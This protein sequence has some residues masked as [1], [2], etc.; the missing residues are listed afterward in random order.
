MCEIVENQSCRQFFFLTYIISQPQFSLPA[1]LPVSAPNLPSSPHHSSCFP[2][3]N[4]QVFRG[5]QQNITSYNKTRHILSYQG[6]T[7]ATQLEEK[8]PRGRQKESETAPTPTTRS[9]TNTPS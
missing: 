8:G 5:Y 2:S 6:W 9:P 7:E 4:E 1:L 3:K